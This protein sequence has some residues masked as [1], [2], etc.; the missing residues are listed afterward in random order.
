MARDERAVRRSAGEGTISSLSVWLFFHSFLLERVLSFLFWE[1][2]FFKARCSLGRPSVVGIHPQKMHHPVPL[3]FSFLQSAWRSRR[4]LLPLFA[5]V[6]SFGCV[7]LLSL[8]GIKERKRKGAN[9]GKKTSVCVYI[10]APSGTSHA[11]T[12]RGADTRKE[13]NH[14]KMNTDRVCSCYNEY[15]RIHRRLGFTIKNLTLFSL[16]LSLSLSSQ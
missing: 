15:A 13:K 16:S 9:G 5:F 12:R 2:F 11:H 1:K 7:G 14:E 6:R 4:S 8:Q 10:F 3:S